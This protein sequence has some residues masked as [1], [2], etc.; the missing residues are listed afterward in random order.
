MVDTGKA[1]QD[2]NREDGIESE[3]GEAVARASQLGKS[4]RVTVLMVDCFEVGLL[5]LGKA[6][7]ICPCV[8]V[9]GASGR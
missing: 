5:G 3:G 8:S 2:L 4:N 9:D 7:R 1:V 6:P